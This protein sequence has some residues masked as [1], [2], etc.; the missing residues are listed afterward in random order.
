M[1]GIDV[2]TALQRRHPAFLIFPRVVFSSSLWAA[3]KRTSFQFVDDRVKIES[4]RQT[5]LLPVLSVTSIGENASG[6]GVANL[7]L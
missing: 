7:F 4:V 2:T 6:N 3:L 5:E 1:D